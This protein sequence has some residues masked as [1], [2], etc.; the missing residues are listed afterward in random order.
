MLSGMCESGYMHAAS[1]GVPLKTN[2]ED[3]TLPS[4]RALP[5]G[6]GRGTFE[7]NT[8]MYHRR[9]TPDEHDWT[10]FD[11][12]R[13][14]KSFVEMI[15]GRIKKGPKVMTDEHSGYKKLGEVGYDHATV[16]HTRMPPVPTTW[17]NCKYRVGLLRWWMM[18]WNVSSA[19][20]I[21]APEL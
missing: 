9:A 7:K 12:P 14:G 2:G 1:K 5:R 11:V 6:P 18:D 8:P 16:N 10:I 21:I 17:Y 13:E 15:Q 4:R 3:R 19:W 20:N